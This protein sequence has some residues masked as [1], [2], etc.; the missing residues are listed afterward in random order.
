MGLIKELLSTASEQIRSTPLDLTPWLATIIGWVV[1]L[2]AAIIPNIISFF[3]ERSFRKDIKQLKKDAGI[4]VDRAKYLEKESKFLKQLHKIRNELIK[5]TWGVT[6]VHDIDILL[7]DLSFYSTQLQFCA[8]DVDK[9]KCLLDKV[10]SE[11]SLEEKRV[12]VG[13]IE[14][15]I[16]VLDKGENSI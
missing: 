8:E 12:S 13:E 6:T 11:K 9:I 3:L 14:E 4:H 10:R 16:L 2:I 1:T 15:I 7:T 5:N